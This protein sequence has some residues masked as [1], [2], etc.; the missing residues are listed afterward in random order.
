LAING[1][2]WLGAILWIAVLWTDDSKLALA[3]MALAS[4]AILA[5]LVVFRSSAR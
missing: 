2:A 4:L 3:L 1:L 5:S